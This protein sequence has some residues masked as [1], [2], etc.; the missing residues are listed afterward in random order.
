M[1]VSFM[2]TP[3]TLRLTTPRDYLSEAA[4]MNAHS[5]TGSS[6]NV[7]GVHTRDIQHAGR[8]VLRPVLM[9]K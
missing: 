6:C 8:S 3:D 5:C 7:R 4:H 2:T 1:P 9:L